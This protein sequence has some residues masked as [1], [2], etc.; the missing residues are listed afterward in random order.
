MLECPSHLAGARMAPFSTNENDGFCHADNASQLPFSCCLLPVVTQ[1]CQTPQLRTEGS[2]GLT[3]EQ[4]SCGFVNGRQL[5]G[6]R[7]FWL[8]TTTCGRII[9]PSSI[10]FLICVLEKLINSQSVKAME[11]F[12]S[13]QPVDYNLGDS[14]LES[15]VA[16]ST[17]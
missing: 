12:Y 2:F 6:M 4:A 7:I 16:C 15:S 17:C 14:L 9:N 11:H 8:S 13:S 1:Q 3:Q 5:L 10:I